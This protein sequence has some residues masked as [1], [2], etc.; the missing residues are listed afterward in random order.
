VEEID[1]SDELLGMIQK[2]KIDAVISVDRR[3]AAPVGNM[4]QLGSCEAFE[5]FA[6]NAPTASTIIG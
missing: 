5:Q 1:R 4:Q 6:G 2:E 3:T